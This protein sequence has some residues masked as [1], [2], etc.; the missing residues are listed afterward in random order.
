[1][2]AFRLRSFSTLC[3]I[4]TIISISRL[5]SNLIVEVEVSTIMSISRLKANLIVEV[6]VSRINHYYHVISL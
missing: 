5:R 2:E 3:A 6:E 1:M 4:K